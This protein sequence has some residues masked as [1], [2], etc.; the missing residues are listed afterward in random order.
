M[1]AQYNINI[2][3]LAERYLIKLMEKGKA[4]EIEQENQ[5]DEIDNLIRQVNDEE[6]S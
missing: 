6:E 4:P 2:K 3:K 1:R 5:L